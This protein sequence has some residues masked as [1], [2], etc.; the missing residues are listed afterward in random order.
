M[1]VHVAPGPIDTPM[2]HWNHWVLKEKGDPHFVGLIR[3]R[4]PSLYGAIFRG[5]D[6]TALNRV[7]EELNLDG[8]AVLGVF[9]RYK[10]R[11][12]ELEES[13]AGITTPESLAAYLGTLMLKE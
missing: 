3:S 1:A 2:L 7:I 9:E 4:L 6:E 11:R 10:L 12:R 5:G 13:A 8:R